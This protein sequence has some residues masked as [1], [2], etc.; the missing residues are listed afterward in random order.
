M[1]RSPLK[2][3]L[4]LLLSGAIAMAC[5]QIAGIE[6]REF[7]GDAAARERQAT[8]QEY[9]NT[10][11]DACPYPGQPTLHSK[12]YTSEEI[13]LATCNLLPTG[14]V[15]EPASTQNSVRCRLNAALQAKNASDAEKDD[16]CQA[17]GPGG[18]GDCGSN[19]E[20][21]C[22]LVEQ[23]CDG[24]NAV[25]PDCE[26]KCRA[27]GD[28]KRFEVGNAM[29]Q[30]DH[31][32][33]TVQCRLVH[34]SSAAVDPE[35]HCG[36]AD[37]HSSNWCVLEEPSCEHYCQVLHYAC[38]GSNRVYGSDEQCMTACEALE[39]G[40]DVR[41]DTGDNIGCRT[42]HAVSALSSPGTHCPHA[43]PTGDGHC[44]LDDKDEG[45]FG[46]CRPYCR[47]LEAACGE[48]FAQT[49]DDQA[50]CVSEC[51]QS[52]ESFGASGNQGYSVE[53]ALASGDTLMC[54][55]LLAVRALYD[56]D[57]FN[58]DAAFGAA[59]CD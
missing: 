53:A 44:G 17:A 45:T 8:C 30:A 7:E 56:G 55:T 25:V 32:G 9:C 11:A 51:D 54:R 20:S 24:I 39:L 52:D 6:D 43:G 38:T 18:N 48:R 33:D 3:S 2:T 21:Y 46:P 27:F 23:A 5:A 47:L 57:P 34:A 37:F 29:E 35:G 13:C 4:A 41:D 10:V 31:S 49:W 14:S 15:D 40:D 36:H 19:C 28:S 22:L 16:F 58:C 26:N 42:W 12:D 59:P 50:A 1:Q